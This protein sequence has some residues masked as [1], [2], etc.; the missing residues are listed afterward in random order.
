MLAVQFQSIQE[1][2]VRDTR[3]MW[4]LRADLKEEQELQVDLLEQIRKYEQMLENYRKQKEESK[5]TALR[6]TL[7]ELKKEAGL[8]EMTGNG[9]II[10]VEPLFQLDLAGVSSHQISP[11]LLIRTINE[12][13]SYGAESISINGHRVISST[14]IRDIN[15][16]TKIDG[17]NLN[18]FP[19]TIQI[20]TE[21]A[22]KL[23]NRINGS[24]LKDDYAIDNLSLSISEP[25]GN[26]VVPAYKETIRI[27]NM[28]P[29]NIE[30][31][32]NS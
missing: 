13:N 24:S 28:E 10:T 26:I 30:K 16:I 25:E 11:Q 22:E 2:V 5:E 21:D 12:L 18:G 3:D 17:S 27:K 31:E 32:G 4:E 9:V 29:F 20:I 15:G 6:E 7:D 23:Y 1:P 8:T 19:I 14:V